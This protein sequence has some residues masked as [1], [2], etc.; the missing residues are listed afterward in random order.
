MSEM[1]CGHLCLFT[2]VR[3]NSSL[4]VANLRERFVDF[5]AALESGQGQIQIMTDHDRRLPEAQRAVAPGGKLLPVPGALFSGKCRSPFGVWERE[6]SGPRRSQPLGRQS[7]C[8]TTRCLKFKTANGGLAVR[9]A[10]VTG[11]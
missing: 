9:S 5:Q 10:V 7:Q 3:N 1:R 4:A 6:R 2:D 11:L 8:R